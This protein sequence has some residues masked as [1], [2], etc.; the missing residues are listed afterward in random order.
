MLALY[1]LGTDNTL[2]HDRKYLKTEFERHKPSLGS[3]LGAY[4][5]CF[6]VAFLEPPSNKNNP[7]SLLNRIADHSL[8]AQDIMAKMDASMPAL[9]TILHEV[10]Q[11]V[12][13]EKV[14]NM[15]LLC[16]ICID[17]YCFIELSRSTTRD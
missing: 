1:T 15:D 16:I 8:E 7:L 11:Y 10:E 5:S 6:P 13:S 4:S 14:Q 17:A 3:C 9:E 12:E 2:S